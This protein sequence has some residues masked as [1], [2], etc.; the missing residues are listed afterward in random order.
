MTE[1]PFFSVVIPTYNREE[2]LARCL[3]SLAGLDYSRNRLE[4]VVVND[5]GAAPDTAAGHL[6]RDLEVKLIN[7]KH[8]G[9]AAA[10]NNG[11]ARARG[12]FLAFTDDDCA[13]DPHWLRALAESLRAWPDHLVGGQTV[14]GLPQN[15]FSTASQLLASYVY[16]YYNKNPHAAHFFAS[17]NMALSAD[18]LRAIGGFDS[19]YTR[20]AAEDRD[21]CDRWRYHGYRMTYAPDAVVH[22]S[23]ELTLRAFCR[24]HFNYGRGAH[25]FHQARSARHQK[26]IRLEPPSFYTN[27]LRYAF[28]HPGS[29]RPVVLAALLVLSQTANAAG[30]FY[31]ATNRT[32]Y[33][34]GAA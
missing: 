21:L 17:N 4:V 16:S 8:S 18:R 6:G 34:Q 28:A 3:N 5:G 31:E 30:F 9:S 33:R 11:A 12:E 32:R 25:Q 7:Q 15:V 26:P 14:N 22:H 29:H 20:T 13:P 27:M 1:D 10:R 2:K 24:Q 19:N 23:H